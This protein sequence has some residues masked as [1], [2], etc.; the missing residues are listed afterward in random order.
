MVSLTINGKK[1]G[2]PSKLDKVLS[3]TTTGKTRGRPRKCTLSPLQVKAIKVV[4]QMVD[5][6]QDLVNSPSHYTAGGIETIDFI[7]A[8]LTKEQYEGYLLGNTIKY[9]SRL[10]LKGQPV[11]DAGKLHWYT[12]ELEK[13][14]H[15]NTK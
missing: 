1:R 2:H 10:G 8:K 12:K 11:L 14:H 13:L 4:Q 15:G 5:K 9:A 7:K 3:A 6:P